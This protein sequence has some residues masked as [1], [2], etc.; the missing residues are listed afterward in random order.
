M[1]RTNKDEIEKM[2]HGNKGD[3][4]TFRMGGKDYAQFRKVNMMKIH[5]VN[6]N[7][8]E[9]D[10]EEIYEDNLPFP[11]F[12]NPPLRT[13]F[14]AKCN[15][16][17]MFVEN[18]RRHIPYQ[19]A[20]LSATSRCDQIW[21]PDGLS[22]DAPILHLANTYDVSAGKFKFDQDLALVDGG[23]NGFVCGSG[24]SRPMDD[25]HPSDR[26]VHITGVGNH[27]INDKQIGRYCSVVPSNQGPKLAIV[28][29]G[30]DGGIHQK[31]TILSVNQMRD[32]G[33]IV[34]DVAHQFRGNQ[35]ITVGNVI[36]PLKFKNGLMYLPMRKPTLEEMNGGLE[37]IILTSDQV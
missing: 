18:C 15:N 11:P 23:A 8:C 20:P 1:L 33:I 26:H 31:T 12:E 21:A 27:L 35:C 4:T 36:L 37:Q 9:L 10:D 29:E 24:D 30:A 16:Q 25:P 7:D 3:L 2:L 6:F 34:D 28:H 14:A 13:A 5:T 19:D 17:T 32:Y 22:Q